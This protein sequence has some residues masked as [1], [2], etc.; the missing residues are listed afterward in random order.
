MSTVK[1]R[2]ANFAFYDRSGIARHLEKMAVKGWMLESAGNTLMKYRR[3]EP[4]QLHFSVTYYADASQFDPGPT[5]GQQILAEFCSRDGWQ[6]VCSWGQMQ[7]FC[8]ENPD[9]APIETDPVIQVENI[10]KS[11]KKNLLW[12][13]LAGIGLSIWCLFLAV[14]Q[15]RSNPVRFLSEPIQ[16]MQFLVWPILLISMVWSLIEYFTWHRKAVQDAENGMFREMKVAGWIPWAL[17]ILSLVL[18]AVAAL[19]TQTGRKAMLFFMIVMLLVSVS[20]RVCT[21][22]LKKKG[23][24]RGV[25]RTVSILVVVVVDLA[26]MGGVTYAMIQSNFLDDRKP[27]EIYD[28]NGWQ[29]EVYNDPIPLTVEDLYGNFDLRWSGERADAGSTFL[30]STA[31][32]RQWALTQN[33]EVPSIDYRITDVKLPELYSFVHDAL[34]D[35]YRDEHVNALYNISFLLQDGLVPVDAAPWGADEAWQRVRGE[36]PTNEYLL[37]YGSRFVQIYFDEPV[38]EAQMATVG[39]LLGNP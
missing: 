13:S 32:Y 27:V 29:R 36:S 3:I 10:H 30:L 22:L 20:G 9:P 35:S 38:T 12:T 19:T 6:F 8:N 37:C 25:N 11:M 39:R 17:T 33:R 24:S 15:F 2:L 28:D 23:V 26:L 31:S 4:K 21:H 34:I 18:L 16:L 7:I 14:S 1:Y 5:E